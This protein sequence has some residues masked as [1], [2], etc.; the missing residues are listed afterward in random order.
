M[1]VSARDLYTLNDQY[2]E[3]LF[4][5]RSI[6]LAGYVIFLYECIVT[7]PDEVKY[8]WPTRWSLVKIIYLL[9]RY[10]NM[11][12]L[13]LAD[14]QLLGIWWSPSPNFCY[15][16]T[17][18][19]TFV[20]LVSFALIHILVLLRAWAT[21][22]RQK[23]MLTVLGSLFIVFGAVSITMLTY[24]VIDKRVG[25]EYP[26]TSFTRSCI[27]VIP[28]HAWVLWVPSLL[29]EC[30]TFTLTMASIRHYNLHRHFFEQSTVVRVLCR[31]GI[32][33]FLVT[34]FSNTFNIL[35]WARDSDR[36]LYMLSNSFTLCL[37]IV[38][39]QRLVLDLR[40]VTDAHDG[41]STTRVGREVERAIEALPPSRSPSPIVF[42]AQSLD[43]VS[44][45]GRTHTIGVVGDRNGGMWVKGR[46]AEG[47]ELIALRGG[48][49][50]DGRTLHV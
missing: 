4:V 1:R 11:I 9:N 18:M 30:T 39:G 17:L 37:L 50:D 14:A 25:D 40:K 6:S 33:Y 44:A 3:D 43:A 35:V 13:A 41:P 47:I 26:H 34:L 32:V 19:F 36:P 42:V 29:L 23:K 12:F 15:R 22:G 21:W 2:L 38:A 31:D 49:R 20:Q 48:E 24:G 7:F 27:G 8:I 16:T 10:G 5:V 45:L 46:V 28:D